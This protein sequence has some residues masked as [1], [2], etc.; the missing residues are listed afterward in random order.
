MQ[1]LAV[2]L[3]PQADFKAIE[4][5]VDEVCSAEGLTCR[6]KS[7]LKKY[8]G[9]IHWHFKQN[10]QPGVLEITLWP[11][12]GRLWVVVREGRRAPWVD[13][14]APYLQ[15]KLEQVISEGRG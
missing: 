14:M 10:R 3:P 8:A 9:S 1:E 4:G 5:L 12:A 13:E 2:T 11:Q 7:G 6:L 15:K